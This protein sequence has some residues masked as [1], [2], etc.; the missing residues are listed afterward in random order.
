MVV[1]C[2]VDLIVLIS[3]IVMVIGLMLFGIGVM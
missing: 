2:L 3:S 1:V